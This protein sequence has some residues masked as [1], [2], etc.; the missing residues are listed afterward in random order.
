MDG[1]GRSKG[2]KE[3]GMKEKRGKKEGEER[4]RRRRRGMGRREICFPNQKHM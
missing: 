1:E 2:D 3:E 4:G